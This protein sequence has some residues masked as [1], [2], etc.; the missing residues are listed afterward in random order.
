LSQ[1]CPKNRRL[2][3]GKRVDAADGFS[4]PDPLQSNA[5]HTIANAIERY[6][7]RVEVSQAPDT[8][9][10][11]KQSLRQFERW[12]DRKFVDEID[13][14]HL[15]AYRK[16]LLKSGNEKKSAKSNG[17]DK[18][19]ADWKVFR[20]NK[21]VKTTLGLPHGKGPIKKSDLG[22]MKPNGPPKIVL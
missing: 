9:K 13:H 14:D 22:I 16:W 10:A 18:L 20:V 8:L 4:R 2:C 12:T 1:I 6:L 19:T 7:Q 11:Y 21:L 17:N 3:P 15:M 5:R